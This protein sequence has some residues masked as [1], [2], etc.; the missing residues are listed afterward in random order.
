MNRIAVIDLGTNTFH[1]QITDTGSDEMPGNVFKLTLPVKLGEG[2]INQGIIQPEAMLRGI[3][4][5]EQ[6]TG[7]ISRFRPDQISAVA[8]AAIRDAKNGNDF[9][10]RVQE[11]T[12]IKIK[13]I[14]GEEEARLIY[15][16]VRRT[17]SMDDKI[18]L[19]MDIGG[20]SVEFV[21]CNE[22][23]IFWRKSYPLG[24]ARLM[25]RFH[26]SDPISVDE[27]KLLDLFF[28]DTLGDLLKEC[29][30]RKPEQLI[31]SA[32]AF[33]SFRELIKGK[34]HIAESEFYT[35]GTEIN[36]AQFKQIAGILVMSTHQQRCK[37]PGLIALRVDMIVVSALLTSYILRKTPVQKI[38]VSDFSLREGIFFSLTSGTR[39]AK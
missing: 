15:L 8:T 17:V 30:K 13:V 20:G 37:M 28:D 31:G 4:A 35:S 7:H 14:D 25:D 11:L 3:D 39:T 23:E 2:G 12:G 33:S 36:P 38:W 34:F 29:D 32:G 22:S 16:G 19:T 26:R 6:F 21:I 18:S 5:I 10:N 27:Q 1:L 9:V 24:A